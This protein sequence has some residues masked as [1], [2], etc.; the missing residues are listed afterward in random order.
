MIEHMECTSNITKDN[1]RFVL[2]KNNKTRF[3]RLQNTKDINNFYFYTIVHIVKS[4][5][6]NHCFQ[7]GF[8]GSISNI[9]IRQMLL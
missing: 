5:T 3:F 9:N 4:F 8:R 7:N 6:K 1:T 2:R